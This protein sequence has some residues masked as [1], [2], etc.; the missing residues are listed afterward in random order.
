VTEVSSERKMLVLRRTLMVYVVIFILW[1]LYRLLFRF[2]VFIE[3]LVFKPLVFLPPL[4]SV[5]VGEGRGWR[6]SWRAFGFRKKGLTLSI[7]YGLTLGIVYVLAA[8]LGNLIFSKEMI[9][10]GFSVGSWR[11]LTV[12]TL[13]LATAF[14]EQIVFSG[15]MLLR[16][17]RI[18]K[19][20][21]GSA[22][23]TSF[24]FTLL[25]LPIL[26]LEVKPELPFILI[27]MLLFFLVGFGNA[28]LMLRTRNIVAPVLSHTFW[29]L[30][31]G[32]FV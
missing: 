14:W 5:L 8:R 24:L 6:Q 20:E 9:L 30:A 11:L 27:Q 28:V 22:F 23:L 31:V 10:Y 12:F 16:F 32:L 3:E 29:A 25:H 7:Y 21:W 26:L 13:S 17:M 1:G 2:P 15:F 4:F 18:L 19:D